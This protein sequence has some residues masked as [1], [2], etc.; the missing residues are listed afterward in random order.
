MFSTL[1][2]LARPLHDAGAI[3]SGTQLQREKTPA[4]ELRGVSYF[5]GNGRLSIQSI[6]WIVNWRAKQVPR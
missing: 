6:S 2:A 1:F 3:S 4:L 5:A